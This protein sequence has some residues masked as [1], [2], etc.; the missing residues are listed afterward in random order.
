MTRRWDIDGES[1]LRRFNHRGPPYHLHPDR[2]MPAAQS[3]GSRLS[4]RGYG[5]PTHEVSQSEHE[6]EQD[7]KSMARKRI[8]VAVC[9][10]AFG[11]AMKHFP[12]TLIWNKVLT[13]GCFNSVVVAASGRSVVVVPE[14]I[15]VA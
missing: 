14:G 7:G 11:R 9:P 10:L 8:P 4:T 13:S 3:D 5:L 12:A 1:P 6:S 15:A 2:Y